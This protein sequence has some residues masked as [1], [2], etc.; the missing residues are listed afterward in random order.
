MSIQ[1]WAKDTI[2]KL[3]PIGDYKPVLDDYRIR[4]FK[5]QMGYDGKLSDFHGDYI[6]VTIGNL[7]NPNI[8]SAVSIEVDPQ[9]VNFYKVVEVENPKDIPKTIDKMVKAAIKKS[10]RY[11]RESDMSKVEKLIE[12]NLSEGM[13]NIDMKFLLTEMKKAFGSNVSSGS[14][15]SIELS[16]GSLTGIILYPNGKWDMEE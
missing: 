10:S 15:G 13:G 9:A 6:N 16:V 7:Q 1:Q 3:K 8:P 12:K 4:Y 14:Q 2:R 5:P 11:S